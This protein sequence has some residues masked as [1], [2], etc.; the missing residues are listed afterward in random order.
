MLVAL[1]EMYGLVDSPL[2]MFKWPEPDQVKFEKA[3]NKC[4]AHY[5]WLAKEALS[6]AA[7]LGN[8]IFSATCLNCQLA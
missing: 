1:N 2:H 8:F 4:L 5:G 6:K 7:W 3:I